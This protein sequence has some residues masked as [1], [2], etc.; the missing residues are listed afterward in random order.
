MVPYDFG[1]AVSG[2]R[3]NSTVRLGP[4]EPWALGIRREKRALLDADPKSGVKLL[5]EKLETK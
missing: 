3:L 5:N 4:N 1:C 2:H